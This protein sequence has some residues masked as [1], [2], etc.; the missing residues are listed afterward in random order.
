MIAA[1]LGEDPA[2]VKQIIGQRFF[3]HGDR[4]LG[5][6]T[7]LLSTGQTWNPKEKQVFPDGES[8]LVDPLADHPHD[9]LASYAAAYLA[10]SQPGGPKDFGNLIE[11]GTH[12]SS[13]FH[14][15]ADFHD[16]WNRWHDGRAP[17]GDES[18]QK[19]ER[20]R[21]LAFIER[22]Q[23]LFAWGLLMEVRHA[24][25]CGEFDRGFAAAFQR[26]E[27]VPGLEYAARY[28]R[29]G[30]VLEAGRLI[31][32]R[33][34]FRKLFTETLEAGIVPPIDST[35]YRAMLIGEDGGQWPA[36]I[37]A[38]A[39][40]LIDAGARPSAVYL[41]RM[42]QQVGDAALA[43]ELFDMALRDAPESPRLGLTLAR[44]AHDRQTARLPRADAL[45]Q[46]LLADKRYAGSPALWYLAEAIADAR[47]MT[48]R[49][50]GFRQKALDIEFTCL[51]EKVN[52]EAIR[53]DYSQLLARYEK[54]VTAIGPFREAASQDLLAAVI[55]AADRWR[56]L[57]PDPTAACQAA[58]RIFGELGET[59]LAWDYL[60]TPLAVQANA[61][62]GWANLARTLR[63]QG[64]FDLADRAYAAAF[65]AEPTNA[66]ILWD[67]AESLQENGRPDQALPIF[68]QIA[69]G[70]RGPQFSGLQE[71]AKQQV[72]K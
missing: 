64:Q 51:P 11:A 32:A 26:F 14:Q 62:S 24:L 20:E 9:P 13:F 42:V 39:K 56:Q 59:D 38:A 30:A 17:Q 37:R 53:A 1:D 6:Y 41:A 22:A 36:T 63:Q 72:A 8:L 65:A 45:L 16:L 12:D 18:Q 40:K 70:A 54:L 43:D 69:A 57:D 49:A 21:A 50:I 67:R 44:I 35:F 10:S 34:L 27:S 15:L 23:P 4:R 55:R 29:A 19:Q 68:R 58:A 28:E 25:N 31:E 46:S 33:D 2:E 47:G 60:T 66:Q 3:R 61:A 7:L 52:V 5:L 48:A 71:R